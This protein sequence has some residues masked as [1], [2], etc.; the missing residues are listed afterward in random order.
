MHPL[1]AEMVDKIRPLRTAA[2][3]AAERAKT[4]SDLK[5]APA[6]I[7]PYAKEAAEAT[8][9][10]QAIYAQVDREL[11]TVHYRLKNDGD[12]LQ[13]FRERF[14]KDD[15]SD[16]VKLLTPYWQKMQ[17]NEEFLVSVKQLIARE[18]PEF[19]AR[20]KAEAAKKKEVQDILRY[21]KR[22]DKTQKPE[23][24]TEKFKRLEELIGKKAAADYKPLLD[25]ILAKKK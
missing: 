17:H 25:K 6:A 23:T 14:K 2:A 13:R 18:S 24:A 22:K 16:V 19:V 3:S 11:A 21:F 12:Y 8:E 20:Q 4:M 7:A 10:Y 5:A 9:A 15:V 1:V